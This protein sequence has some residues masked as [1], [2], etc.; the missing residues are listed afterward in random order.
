MKIKEFDDYIDELPDDGNIDRP[1]GF[2][3]SHYP[4]IHCN[5]SLEDID[6]DNYGYAYGITK[7]QIPFEA[8]LWYGHNPES[9]NVTFYI[10]E[11]PEFDELEGEPLINATTGTGVFNYQVERQYGMALCIGMVEREQIENLTVLDTYVSLL[12]D[13]GLIA[14]SSNVLNGSVWRYT[15]FDGNNIVAINVTLLEDD[16][17]MALTP[18]EWIPFV[19]DYYNKMPKL[20]LVK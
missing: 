8:E 15:D 6:S 4:L 14:F 11:I 17:L 1:D 16:E 3:Q 13:S 12:I 18:L 7:D 9:T 5:H 10:P 20:R 2:I 19:P